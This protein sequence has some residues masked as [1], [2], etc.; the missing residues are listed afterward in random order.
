MIT[1]V[2][3]KPADKGKR[4]A[5]SL[6][7]VVVTMTILAIVVSFAAPR[8]M[9]TL[10]QSH[11]DLAGANLRMIN[12][13]QRFHW[14][15]NR[16]YADN[17]EALID[18]GLLDR[19]FDAAAPRYEF[20]IVSGDDTGFVAEARRR[21]FDDLDQPVYDGSWQGTL[22][23]DESGTISGTVDSTGLATVRH[24]TPGF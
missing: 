7:E 10:E 12:S 16:T 3:I 17:I 11:A 1:S 21:V 13:A 22:T 8:V 20:R 9:Q 18:D 5:F 23:I 19:S 15:E 6:I 4:S 24:L 14:L 2:A